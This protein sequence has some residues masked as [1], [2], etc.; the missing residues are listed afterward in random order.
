MIFK[1]KI[2]GFA[3]GARLS[4]TVMENY[5]ARLPALCALKSDISF[6]YQVIFLYKEHLHDWDNAESSMLLKKKGARITMKESITQLV[7]LFQNMTVC[8]MKMASLQL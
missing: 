8:L 3:A 7:P 4:R 1:G 6:F 5:L 2:V